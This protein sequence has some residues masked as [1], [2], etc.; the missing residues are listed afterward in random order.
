MSRSKTASRGLSLLQTF[1]KV[2]R[3]KKEKRRGKKKR[4]TK[5]MTWNE[6]QKCSFLIIPIVPVAAFRCTLG[7]IWNKAINKACE[8]FKCLKTAEKLNIRLLSSQINGLSFIASHQ[9][10]LVVTWSQIYRTKPKP[11][12]SPLPDVTFKC[13]F[14][15]L[16]LKVSVNTVGH[17]YSWIRHTCGASWLV[18]L[19]KSSC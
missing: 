10:P 7:D 13:L 14:L 9:P 15:N 11:A 19:S 6:S 3:E 4:K 5:E 1:V 8:A 17:S 12:A 18:E 2:L 16:Y